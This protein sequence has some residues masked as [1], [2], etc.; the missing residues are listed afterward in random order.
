[1]FERKWQDRV[2]NPP[3]K[4]FQ[5]VHF[6]FSYQRKHQRF[7]RPKNADDF[8]EFMR[9]ATSQTGNEGNKQ[10]TDENFLR[11]LSSS[12]TCEL[13]WVCAIIGGILSQEIIKVLSGKDEPINNF[14]FFDG[15]LDFTRQQQLGVVQRI[16]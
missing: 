6:L 15:S 7:P 14:F 11:S 8:T 4:I 5:A 9:V 3:N 10:P 12:S 16:E 13:P 2:G 1:V